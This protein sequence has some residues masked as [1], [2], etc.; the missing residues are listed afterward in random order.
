ML[1]PS[2]SPGASDSVAS[3]VVEAQAL[4]AWASGVVARGLS[5]FAACGI[6]LG[7]G[8]NQRPLGWQVDSY[9]LHHQGSG[10]FYF[11][12]FIKPLCCR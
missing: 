9:P 7:Q 5:C 10:G 12:K 11:L 8:S 3:L 2:C 4:G 1:L 6:F